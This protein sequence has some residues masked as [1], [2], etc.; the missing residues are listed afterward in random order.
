MRTYLFMIIFSA[1]IL[2]KAE[3]TDCDDFTVS[4]T[5]PNDCKDR[6]KELGDDSYCCYM[7]GDYLTAKNAKTCLNI[8]KNDYKNV[9][10]FIKTSNEKYASVNI[11]KLDCK[12]F[13][14]HLSLINLILFLF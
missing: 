10:K 9:D 2:I 4:A 1:I 11:Q 7:E 6:K 14:L 3:T 12:S 8:G 5:G 13:Y